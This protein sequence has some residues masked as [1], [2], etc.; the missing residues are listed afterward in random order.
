MDE[1]DLLRAA[2]TLIDEKKGEETVIIDLQE[3]SIPTSYFLI[4]EADNPAHVK[5]IISNL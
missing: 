5:A 2:A 1:T 4:T 3:E